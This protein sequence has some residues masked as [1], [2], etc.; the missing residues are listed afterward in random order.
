[1]ISHDHYDHLDMRSVQFFRDKETTFLV[2]LG[3]KSH[4][5]YWGVATK[6]IIELDW[7]AEHEFEGIRFVCTPAQHFSGWTGT[8]QT[9]LWASWVVDSPNSKIYFSGDSGYDE[10]YQKLPINLALLMRPLSIV[11]N[12]MSVGEKSTICL[13]K[14]LGLPLI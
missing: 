12:T 11:A 10:H 13:K 6:K 7:W 8:N 5:E 3:I 2:P 4:L 1:M 14:L 9:T